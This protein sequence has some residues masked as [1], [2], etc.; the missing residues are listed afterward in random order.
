MELMIFKSM[1]MTHDAIYKS[2]YNY[3]N[4]IVSLYII[5]LGIILMYMALICYF[6]QIYH[7]WEGYCVNCNSL[8]HK[9]T[10]QVDKMT[11]LNNSN[12]KIA[13]K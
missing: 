11:L 9:A 3:H 2:A 1:I 5:R 6:V 10:N 13:W 7:V 8:M 12:M 4:I